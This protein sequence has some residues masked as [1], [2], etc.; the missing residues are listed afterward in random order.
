M[1]ARSIFA[2][3]L[4]LAPLAA[5][6]APARAGDPDGLLPGLPAHAAPG[7]CYAH[8]KAAARLGPPG[9]ATA[10]WRLTPP[11]PGA[12]GP[13]WCLVTEPGAPPQVVAPERDGWIRVL[14]DADATPVRIRR[15]QHRLHER[16]M[17]AGA[18]S[19]RYDADTAAAVSRF[20]SAQHLAH[21]GYLSLRTVEAIEGGGYDRPA[22]PPAP[23]EA[24][25][26]PP[27]PP[28]VVV[29]QAPQAC[30]QASPWLSWPG[31]RR[32]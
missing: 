22:T 10:H 9:P 15:L 8:V 2:A 3:V 18:E 11:P 19:G 32:Y 6:A 12:P 24:A 13:L 29:L 31:K 26:I 14:C 30:C 28:P 25:Y 4:A 20:Q 16:G 7:V 17:Y 23:M 1:S 27:P 5:V 21:G